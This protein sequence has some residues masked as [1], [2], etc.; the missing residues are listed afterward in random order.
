M[1]SLIQV[2]T[3]SF[4]SLSVSPAGS[5]AGPKR[6]VIVPGFF[7]NAFLGQSSPALCATGITDAPV[8]TASR[9]PPALNLPIFPGATRVPSGKMMIDNP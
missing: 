4:S 1:A 3:R 2:S 7:I 8:R 5:I 6:T 9:A